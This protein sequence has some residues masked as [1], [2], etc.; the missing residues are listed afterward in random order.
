MDGM[1]PQ[2]LEDILSC[3]SL[4]T[5][6]AIAV[7]VI[8]MT[9]DPDLVLD[10]LAATIANDQGL[11]AKILRT[12]NSSF[13]GL[14]QK[15]TT[16]HQALVVLGMS[17]V[18]TL[19]L[20]FSLVECVDEPGNNDFDYKTYW[21]R[22]LYTSVAAKLIA[23]E[24]GKDFEDEVFLGGLLQDVGMVAIYRALGA[25]Y[26]DIVARA[27]EDRMLPSLEIAE[28]ELT[29]ADIGAI[30]AER[31]KLPDELVLPIK[32]HH[33][34]TAAPQE[35]LEH[36][37]CVALANTA[38]DV[39]TDE[40]PAPAHQRFVRR[41]SEWF[42]L[43]AGRAETL[44]RRIA[45]SAEEVSSLFRLDTG[46]A[47]DPEEVLAKAQ[48][49][50]VEMARE[51]K[52]VSPY[53]ASLDSLLMDSHRV[54]P[55]TGAMARA[56]FDVAIREAFNESQATGDPL[57]VIL[58]LLD[59][60]DEVVRSRGVQSADDALLC[61]ATLLRKHFEP[62]GAL[63]SRWADSA[64]AVVVPGVGQA[65]TANMCAEFRSDLSR[66]PSCSGNTVSVGA[67]I[68]TAENASVYKRVEQF[69]AAA[70]KAVEAARGAGGNNVKTFVPRAAA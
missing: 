15:C 26:V 69:V 45:A 46:E 17:S 12:V 59:S 20:G 43:N 38:H 32:Y 58:V 55:L 28:L 31:W 29:H 56:A 61:T 34:P 63:V 13:Y 41:C 7:R 54:D 68:M 23:A 65:Q 25:E 57:S 60:F 42:D 33:R 67:A 6:P 40:N 35:L 66:T 11:S 8:E 3:P 18:K 27:G 44:V 36:V 2:T 10:D 62:A 16:I 1:N 50:M 21:R 9:S 51:E 64:F 37:R 39:L 14:R 4:P 48:N 22:S 53:G 24:A 52:K 30:L 5:L 70:A 49:Q 47:A 19:A